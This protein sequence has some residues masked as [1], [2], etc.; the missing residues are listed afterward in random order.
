MIKEETKDNLK[1]INVSKETW[2]RL[3]NDKYKLGLKTQEDVII[4]LYKIVGKMKNAKQN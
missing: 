1:T 4:A 2:R 3:N